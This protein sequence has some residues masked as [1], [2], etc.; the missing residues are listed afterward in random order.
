MDGPLLVLVNVLE[1]D[2]AFGGRFKF[3]CFPLGV[4]GEDSALHIID[5]KI[6]ELEEIILRSPY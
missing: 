2:D 5:L 3:D 1:I 4:V 6:F